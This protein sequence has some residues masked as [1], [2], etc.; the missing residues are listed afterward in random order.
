MNTDI[1][2]KMWL[3]NFKL[4]VIL[5][6]IQ[7]FLFAHKSFA[8]D[9]Q[10]S[11]K[12][13]DSLNTPLGNSQIAVK[14]YS[15]KT[16]TTFQTDPTGNYIVQIP[17]G[18]YTLTVNSPKGSGVPTLKKTNFIVSKSSNEDIMMSAPSKLSTTQKNFGS[19]NFLAKYEI[20]AVALILIGF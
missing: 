4:L 5:I 7:L 13:V 16:V 15:Q 20:G 19:L 10:L 8:A 6:V 2:E 3:R 1:K 12:V 11:G 18:R 14:D 17:P 9:A